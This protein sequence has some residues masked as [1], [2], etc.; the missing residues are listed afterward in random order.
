MKPQLTLSDFEAAAKKLDCDIPAIQA[1]AHVEAPKGGFNPDDTPT[2]LFEGHHFHRFTNGIYDKTFPHLSY[3]R[4]T[5]NHYGK[6][7]QQE[8]TRLQQSMALNRDAAL[9][10]ASWGKFQ[11][12]GFNFRVC[13]YTS[14]QQFVNSMYESEA[15]QLMAFCEFVIYNKLDVPLRRHEWAK[16]AS[17]YNGPRYAENDYDTKLENEFKRFGDK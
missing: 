3:P 10:S 6:S 14:I 1:V 9:K 13:A 15:N 5:R 7:W 11:I 16:F 12:M 2:T 17:G 8:Q 4:W